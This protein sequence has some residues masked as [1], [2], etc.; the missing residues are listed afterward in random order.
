MKTRNLLFGAGIASLCV[1]P[2]LADK[3]HHAHGDENGEEIEWDVAEIFFEL[4]D[5][6]GDLGIHALIDGEPWKRLQIEDLK[7]RRILG[8]GVRSRLRRQGLTEFFFESAEPTF[9][10]LP[11]TTFFR[12]FPEGTYEVEGI[13]L[14]GI[15]IENEVELTHAMPAPP[16]PTVNGIA[17]VAREK[18]DD[19]DP[20][21][22][23]PVIAGDEYIIRWQPVTMTHP[24]LGNPQ[25]A[26]GLVVV[27]YQVVVETDLELPDDEEFT[28]IFS[29]IVPPDVFEMTIPA[30]FM[31]QSDEFKYEVLVRE[32][33]WNQTAIESCFLTEEDD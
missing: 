16:V 22:D 14:D 2:A 33:S 13:S 18:C 19:E 21:Y 26:D 28:A 23:P 3:Y 4:N 32:E 31:N 11:P 25:S 29:A 9:D 24:T 7:E 20:A 6:D 8:V 27:N 1:A 30:E 10:E 15:E 5:T 12:R 17:A